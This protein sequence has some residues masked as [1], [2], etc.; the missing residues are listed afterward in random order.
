[1]CDGL[2]SFTGLLLS[3]FGDV[4]RKVLALCNDDS[5]VSSCASE[6]VACDNIAATHFQLRKRTA[7]E[8]L[9]AL[10]KTGIQCVHS[11]CENPVATM[12]CVV[13]SFGTDTR[14]VK[15]EKDDGKTS[16][17]RRSTFGRWAAFTPGAFLQEC[18]GLA[19]QFRQISI[20]W[21]TRRGS[22]TL[23]PN[24]Y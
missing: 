24:P 10:R 16:L 18:S 22:G 7:P 4:T 17:E 5:K 20:S 21:W 14:T 19:L 9:R 11:W 23:S 1:M 15:P 8:S 13:S 12:A 2:R 6:S 3:G